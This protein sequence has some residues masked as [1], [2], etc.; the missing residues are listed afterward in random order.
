MGRSLLWEA[1]LAS[2]ME[3][4]FETHAEAEMIGHK[5]ASIR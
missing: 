4:E 5:S 1:L 2:S 3:L